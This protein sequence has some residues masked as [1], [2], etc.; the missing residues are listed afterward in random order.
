GR[1]LGLLGFGSIG[2]E[3]ARRAHAFGMPLVVWSRRFSTGQEDSRHLSIPIRT[4]ASPAEA[5]AASD[6]LSV[7][8]ALNADTRGL[9]NDS[10]LNA[11]KRG[12]YLINTAR[13]EV[14]NQEA[15]ARAVETRGLRVG[16]DVFAREPASATGDFAD[17]I[18]SLPNV[19]G[20]HHIGASTEQ[21]QEAI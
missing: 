3:V 18:V 7:H 15:L 16:L 4:A 19:Y 10:V 11:L 2:Q 17:P 12:A 21:A 14:V 5:A 9:V 20:T 6:I 13:G 8:V 1:T